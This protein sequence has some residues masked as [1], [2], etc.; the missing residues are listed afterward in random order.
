MVLEHGAHLGFA[1]DGDADRVMAV[2]EKGQLID[3]DQIMYIC[4]LRMAAAGQLRQATLVTTVMS[5]LGLDVALEKRGIK[6]KR[7]RV[8]DRYVLSEMQRLGA[9][10]GG[11][12]SGHIIFLDHNST[13]DGIVTALQ[14]A[15]ILKETGQSLAQLTAPMPRL[16][17][18]QYNVLVSRKKELSTNPRIQDAIQTANA[19]FASVG[20]VL[21]RPSGTEPKVR[22]MVEGEDGAKLE[23]I[24]GR[25]VQ[26]I[27]EE[28]G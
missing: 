19:V 15:T 20:R 2:D 6:V 28:L 4:A 17:Q 8:G 27:K 11:E 12:Q 13:G 9:N 26:I 14:V 16:P 25:L 5:N 10:L 7:T 1:H 23:E 18:V 22:V 3:G 21:V 24:A